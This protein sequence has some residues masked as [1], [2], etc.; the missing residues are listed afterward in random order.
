MDLGRLL[1]LETLLEMHRHFLETFR[2]L[3]INMYDL[4]HSLVHQPEKHDESLTILR[5]ILR[6]NV[7]RVCRCCVKHAGMPNIQ[8]ITIDLGW[9]CRNPQLMDCLTTETW[10]VLWTLAA[11]VLQRRSRSM[12]CIHSRD[13]A[14]ALGGSGTTHMHHLPVLTAVLERVVN[15]NQRVGMLSIGDVNHANHDR[16]PLLQTILRL[17][18]QRLVLPFRWLGEY[19][20]DH[21]DTKVGHHTTQ[22]MVR[23]PPR[24]ADDIIDWRKMLPCHVFIP[25]VSHVFGNTC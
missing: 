23:T 15:D 1:Q 22:L 24:M 16:V 19:C 20:V 18:T 14:I 11:D 8:S 6:F 21:P 2:N 3:A 17:S 12:V 7:V 4:E 13:P 9:G 5:N 25:Q 10:T